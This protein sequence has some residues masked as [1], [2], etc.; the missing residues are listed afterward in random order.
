MCIYTLTDEPE[1]DSLLDGDF[2]D[3][4]TETYVEEKDDESLW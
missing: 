1:P 3:E 4:T 2:S